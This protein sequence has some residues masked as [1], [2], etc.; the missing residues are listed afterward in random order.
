[1]NKYHIRFNTNHNGSPL[2]WRIF[3]NGVEHLVK[4]FKITSPVHDEVTQENGVEKWNLCCLGHMIIKDNVATIAPNRILPEFV[5]PTRSSQCWEYSGIDSPEKCLDQTHFETYPYPVLYQYNGRG[6]RDQEWPNSIEELKTAIW[7][8]GDSFTV[9]LGSPVEHTWPYLLQ[10]QTQTRT[11]N[12]SLDGASNDWIARKAQ[13]IINTIGPEFLVVH[14]S[15]ISRT[16]KNLNQELEKAWQIFYTNVRDASWPDCSWQNALQLP[17]AIIEEM[18]RLHGGWNNLVI[19]D[20]SL[21]NED[22]GLTE[23]EDVKRTIDLINSL[24]AG[25]RNTKIIHSFIP[26]FQPP[27]RRGSVELQ[28]TGTVIPE[29]KKLDLARDGHHYDIATSR[30]FVQQILAHLNR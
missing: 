5:L 26:D 11:I 4:S 27:T 3:E 25:T 30:A 10:Q 9:G 18:N 21:R 22:S 17:P 24:T 8:V 13:T 6:Y 23:K 28:I 12:I 7:C 19:T 14:W 15:Y 16:E 1:V 2:V 20:E 29:F